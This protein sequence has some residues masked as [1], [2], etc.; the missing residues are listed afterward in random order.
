MLK[1]LQFRTGWKFNL[2]ADG[3]LTQKNSKN[4][5]SL[6]D[7]IVFTASQQCRSSIVTPC[8]RQPVKFLRTSGGGKDFFPNLSLPSKDELEVFR[9]QL[10]IFWRNDHKPQLVMP[11]T[12]TKLK[13]WQ[14]DL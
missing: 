13:W 9:F 2:N 3:P 7:G 4:S 8:I 5:K 11:A 12:S 6:I 14:M 10:L 1:P